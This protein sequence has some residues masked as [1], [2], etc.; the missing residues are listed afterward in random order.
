MHTPPVATSLA[1][2]P[3]ATSRTYPPPLAQTPRPCEQESHLCAEQPSIAAATAA[4]KPAAA[5]ADPPVTAVAERCRWVIR[6]PPL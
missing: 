4:V 6:G 3:A 5:A 1:H 2:L